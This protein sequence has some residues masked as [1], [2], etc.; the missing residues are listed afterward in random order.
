M[1]AIVRLISVPPGRKGW[2]SRK[3]RRRW[4]P[5]TYVCSTARFLTS[6]SS[7][8]LTNCFLSQSRITNQDGR[9]FSLSL[10]K[11]T[12]I[13]LAAFVPILQEWLSYRES[14][15]SWPG[16]GPAPG[17]TRWC[18]RGWGRG[19]GGGSRATSPASR[20]PCS[21][22]ARPFRSCSDDGSSQLHVLGSVQKWAGFGMM[23]I[24]TFLPPIRTS[25]TEKTHGQLSTQ[26]SAAT[27]ETSESTQWRTSQQPKQFQS[28]KSRT[29]WSIESIHIWTHTWTCDR[30]INWRP[31]RKNWF[32]EN[33]TLQCVRQP[34]RNLKF[35]FSNK[36]FFVYMCAHFFCLCVCVYC[37]PGKKIE[38]S[39]GSWKD[40][41]GDRH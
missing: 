13:W 10:L 7:S 20:R 28:V 17:R 40:V 23:T 32:W 24:V 8:D 2:T 15:R 21:L 14:W 18:G 39:C 16:R 35:G 3:T 37:V 33:F 11:R 5:S 26:T 41:M 4:V 9:R 12:L 36:R 38:S 19:R 30:F 22:G 27:M 25:T 6:S 1:M 31:T 34:A 29:S